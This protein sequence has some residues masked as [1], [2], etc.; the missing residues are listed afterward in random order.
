MKELT[1]HERRVL[2]LVR[3]HPEIVKDKLARKKIAVANDMAEK[4][5]R[6]RIAELKRY[7]L[8]PSVTDQHHDE[9]KYYGKKP[10]EIFVSDERNIN[11]F[12]YV[13]TLFKWKWLI[14]S[15]VTFASV[16]AIIVSLTLPLW[17]KSTAVILPPSE[18]SSISALGILGEVGF[19]N[20]LGSDQSQNRYLAIL[21]SK[22]L[23]QKVAKRYN[24]QKKYKAK[25]MDATIETLLNK[26]MKIEVG[27]EMQISVSLWDKDQDLIAEMTDYLI[28]CLD[29]TNISL[30]SSSARNNRKFLEERLNE[31]K[32]ALA[33]AEDRLREFQQQTG[34]VDIV[35][36]VSALLETYGQFYGSK[37]QAYTDLYAQ[38][39]QTE[40]QLN[41][42]RSTFHESNP[43][44]QQL[45]LILHEQNNQLGVLSVELDSQFEQVLE[46]SDQSLGKK[47]TTE[48]REKV[49]LSFEDL[50]SL[51]MANFRLLREI[52]I[53]NKVLEFILPQYEQAKFEEVKDIPTLQLL[54][55]PDRPEKKDRPRRTLIV[56][57]TFVISSFFTVF[58]VILYENY[59][60][61]TVLTF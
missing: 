21:K 53:Q 46:G 37:L 58:G 7:G 18:S 52:E 14:L 28:Y 33:Q 17:Y 54:D 9:T 47:E 1:P 49:L 5:L 15:V 26:K 10:E 29:S 36:Q 48:S 35:T 61:S 12:D 38:Q 3:E 8:I 60:Q 25:D 59:K 6:N 39:V 27:E 45:E 20:I 51:A 41:V 19:G 24:L 57:L 50:P 32:R 30:S 40:I 56:V 16:G 55:R 22:E 11:L 34:V 13:Q 23:L 43:K 2:E 4:T 31:N 44:L 42:A